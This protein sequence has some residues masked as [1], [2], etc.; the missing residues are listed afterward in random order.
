M[1]PTIFAVEHYC[2]IHL[3]MRQNSFLVFG[4]ALLYTVD[5]L[6]NVHVV[7]FKGVYCKSG[8]ICGAL[9]FMN[10]AQNSA[11]AIQKPGKNICDILYAHFGHLLVS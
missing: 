6:S 11:S 3:A 2:N 10:F 9:I 8:N 5:W 1:N 4:A 7:K